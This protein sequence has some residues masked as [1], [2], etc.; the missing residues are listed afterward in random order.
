M[1]FRS[2][3]ISD[4]EYCRALWRDTPGIRLTKA[5]SMDAIASYLRRNP[6]MSFVCVENDE[7]IGTSMC[8]HDGRRGY[9]YHVAVKPEFRGKRIGTRLVE[10][11]LARLKEEGIGKCHLFVVA[12]NA[13]GKAFWASFFQ[14]REDISVYSRD[15]SV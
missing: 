7:V 11:C 14:K 8:G 10:A 15:V 13:L 9:L 1:T 2:M 3:T 5:D 6:G 4:Y 12:G